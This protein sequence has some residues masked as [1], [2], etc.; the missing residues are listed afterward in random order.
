[1]KNISAIR[2][3]LVMLA[4][5]STPAAYADTNLIAIADA[6]T[7]T[8][9]P[10]AHLGSNGILAVANGRVAL[11]RFNAQQIA[12]STGG[13]ATLRLKVV[14]AKNA[15]NA[16]AIRLVRGPWR[17]ATVTA[18]NLPPIAPGA[19]DVQTITRANQGAIVT[20]DI[21]AALAGWRD[22][23][24]TNFGL[25]IVATVPVPNL[26]FGSREGGAP[27][28]FSV[29]GPVQDNDVT[30]A[31]SGGDYTD[32]A[33]AAKN[34]LQGDSWC[35]GAF[36]N[37]RCTI[38]VA[39][40]VYA[41]RTPVELAPGVALVGE[42]KGETLLVSSADPVVHSQGRSLISDLTLIGP[43]GA[44]GMFAVQ[45]PTIERVSLRG[46]GNGAATLGLGAVS[47]LTTITDSDITTS[48]NADAT[49]L[50]CFSCEGQLKLVRL[51]VT[52]RSEGESRAVS[53]FSPDLDS[54]EI[55][56]STIEA[57]GTTLGEGVA[58]SAAR[59][60]QPVL[61][62][63]GRIAASS[64]QIAVGFAGDIFDETSLQLIGTRINVR[65]EQGDNGLVWPRDMLIDGAQIDAGHSAVRVNA[66]SAEPASHEATVLRS[67]FHAADSA[68]EARGFSV[69][70]ESSVLRAA[71]A[72]SMDGEGAS[73]SATSSQ[74]SGNLRTTELIAASCERVYDANLVLLPP[75]CL[76][77]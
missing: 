14:L 46:G 57:S 39:R 53:L 12:Q 36:E 27:A 49:A 71:T 40:G 62:R 18:N 50:Y 60:G 3:A 20:F 23:P 47:G 33:V 63:G 28:E 69:H 15:T 22:D 19:L 64:A 2:R 25:A 54:L 51:N 32:P 76:E 73:L 26:Q 8:S 35:R 66:I 58:I 55:D 13:N 45:G 70:L 52:A 1:M 17:E 38:H 24:A 43:A 75:S 30:V 65:G 11:V 16:V 74:L 21:S 5:L 72:L 29:T 61:V 48:G 77:Q 56:D 31:P 37:P 68:L 34:A 41:L 7:D 10:T 44:I 59:F 4:L 42:E 6:Y 67:Q 9:S